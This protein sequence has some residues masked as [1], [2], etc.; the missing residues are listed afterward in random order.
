MSTSSA[1]APVAQRGPGAEHRPAGLGAITFVLA[2]AVGLAVSNIYFAQPLLSLLAHSFH[3]SDGAVTVIVTVTQVGYA[4]GLF[5]LLPLGDLFE[6]RKLTSIMLVVTAGG[7]A[8]AGAAPWLG[9]FLVASVIIGLTSV[10]AQILIPFAAHLTP[11]ASRGRVMGRLNSGLLLGVMLARTLSSLVAAAWGWRAIFFISSALMLVTACVLFRV[12]PSRRP[13]H[14]AGYVRLM[15]SVAAL[16]RDEPALRQRSLRQALVF[17]GFSAFWS[18]ISYE[19]V[20]RHGF[21]QAEIGLFALVG[22]VGV[23]AAPVAGRLADRGTDR[24]ATGAALL[25][26]PVALVI[27]DLG[28]G[29]VVLLGLAAILLDIGMT[30][31]Q[32]LSQRQIY[33]LRPDARA[34]LN[35]VYMGSAFL[36]GAAGSAIA[37]ALQ[38]PY[39]WTGATLF[40]VSVSAVA[41]VLWAWRRNQAQ[42]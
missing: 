2:A 28:A 6:N 8:L 33:R 39:G 31:N 12:L 22:A 19:L 42:A 23:A 41:L 38:G 26:V 14:T 29:S 15:T 18:S 3:T 36:G 21:N 4:A 34:R 37:G 13:D 30:S 16:V 9:V 35:T 32:I 27:A 20:G 24:Y 1:S 40:G 5:L 17:A 25:L 7:L 10:V 11:E